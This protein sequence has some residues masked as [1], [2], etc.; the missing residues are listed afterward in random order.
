[1]A[2]SSLTPARRHSISIR[3]TSSIILCE[4]SLQ[5]E[6]RLYWGKDLPR[7]LE[8]AGAKVGDSITPRHVASKPVAI[9]QVQE[10]PDGTKQVVR[11]DSKRNSWQVDNHGI[12]RQAVIKAYDSL[13]KIPED[14]KRLERSAP[15]LVAARDVA[16]VELRNSQPSWP[17][18]TR[19]PRTF[20]RSN[21]ER[22]PVR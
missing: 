2:R 16:V 19:K 8:E 18:E 7:A 13:V 10:Q 17:S 1:M 6:Q 4:R 14:R 15:M 11:V 9:E 5:G 22:N 3:R 12:N 21:Y 20:A